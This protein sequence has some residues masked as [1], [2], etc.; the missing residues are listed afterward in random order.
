MSRSVLIVD[1]DIEA[2]DAAVGWLKEAAYDTTAASTFLEGKAALSAR[3]FDLLIANIRLGAYNGIH[4]ALLAK[5]RSP[6]V[7]TILT[8]APENGSLQSEAHRAGA[9]A[10][11]C[12]PHARDAFLS[13]VA[14]TVHADENAQAVPRRW[15]RLTLAKTWKARIEDAQA[16]VV[17]V[18]YGG[19]RVEL[20]N[21]EQH[22][23]GSLLRL[24]TVEPALSIQIRP[25][26]TRQSPL[27]GAWWFGAEVA[28][29]DPAVNDRWRSVV[30]SL[31]SSAA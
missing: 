8:H 7:R 5:H 15:P 28:E 24:D 27:P 22:D 9:Q 12:K 11:L 16:R 10:Y 21:Q 6:H 29:S 19:V 18:S 26:W 31:A 3:V 20:A 4:L 1:A 2:L 23:F 30:D 25:V 14:A 13:A 17:D